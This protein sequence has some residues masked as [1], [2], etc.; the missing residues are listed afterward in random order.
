MN[1]QQLAP[2]PP[3]PAPI[4]GT[5]PGSYFYEKW[6]VDD[7]DDS[8][9]DCDG[10]EISLPTIA[11]GDALHIGG[12]SRGE[13]HDVLVLTG[14]DGE[15]GKLDKVLDDLVP[16]IEQHYYQECAGILSS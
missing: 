3:Q 15:N 8:I 12:F 13:I 1:G 4:R 2:D 10:L 7:P 5:R 14:I 16:F 9:E 11:G 6:C